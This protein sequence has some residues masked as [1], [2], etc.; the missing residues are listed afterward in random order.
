MIHLNIQSICI[1][2]LSVKT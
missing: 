2:V 1:Q